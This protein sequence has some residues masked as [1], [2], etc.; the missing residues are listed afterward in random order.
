VAF[1]TRISKLASRSCFIEK[2]VPRCSLRRR[3]PTEN[4][5]PGKTTRLGM[6]GTCRVL[7]HSYLREGPDFGACLGIARRGEPRA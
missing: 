7:N 3:A 6:C 2:G 5:I 1:P 4:C